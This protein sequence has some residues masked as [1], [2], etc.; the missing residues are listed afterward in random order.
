MSH[1]ID[2]RKSEM[3]KSKTRLIHL[4]EHQDLLEARIV[5]KKIK[6]LDD[7]SG[8]ISTQW[9][10]L[11]T[12]TENPAFS[13]VIGFFTSEKTVGYGSKFEH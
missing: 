4:L 10:P 3:E 13:S 1:E 11:A 2:I 7:V 12:D 8:I 6:G 9:V 5:L